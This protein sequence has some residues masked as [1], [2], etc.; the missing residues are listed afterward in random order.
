MKRR[1]AV[2]LATLALLPAALLAQDPKAA[3]QAAPPRPFDPRQFA[4]PLIH[5]MRADQ[6]KDGSYGGSARTTG[7]ALV[8][9]AKSSRQYREADGP[10]I[11]DA[12]QYLLKSQQ[13]DGSIAAA[14]DKDPVAST[15]AAALAFD[16]LDAKKYAET[17]KQAVAFAAQKT[18]KTAPAAPAGRAL[19]SFVEEASPDVLPHLP[20]DEAEAKELFQA[21]RDEKGGYGDSAKNASRLVL[22]QRLA[23]RIPRPSQTQEAPLKPLPNY[24]PTAKTDID[25]VMRKGIEFLMKRQGPGGE[26]GSPV[27]K[28]QWLGVTALTAQALWA[29]PGTMPKDLL[30][31]AKKA[32]DKV[33]GAARADGS[34]HGSGLENYTT[35]ASVGALVASKDPNYKAV[36][37]KARKFLEG[38]QADEAEGISKDHWSYGGF[39]YGDEERP[40]MSNTQFA[41]D[42]LVAAGAKPNDPALQKALVF[43]TRCQNNSES[44]HTEVSR[45][46]VLAVA[47][48]DG[49]GIYY[50]GNSKAGNEKTADGKEIARSYGSMSYALLKGFVFAGLAKDD[51]RLKA[52]M[53]WCKKNYTLDRVPGYEEMAKVSP[54]VPYQGLYYYYMT[55]ANALA[56]LGVDTIETP[57]G[58]KHDWRAELAARLASL[59]KPDGSWSNDNSPRWYEGDELIA[60]D[61]AILTLKALHR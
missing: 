61:Y 3:A 32:T 48:N 9:F 24:D 15:L 53:D 11:S 8:G 52:V 22:I 60:T 26:Y 1:L 28:D 21:G 34:I 59:Q 37:E 7:L 31:A 18:N 20:M 2:L 56:A 29:W 25:A 14:N 58:K 16:A 33:A 23:D 49:G 57:D 35:S 17:V 42:A 4:N 36:I 30:A 19:E 5:V 55:M 6:Q 47:G 27:T 38:I 44:N 13:K 46:G 43:L 54:R 40:D 51:P 39:G 10:F 50:P 45:D 41:L 12:V